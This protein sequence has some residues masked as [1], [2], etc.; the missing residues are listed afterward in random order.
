[1]EC[2]YPRG[3]HFPARSAEIQV[4]FAGGD[5]ASLPLDLA[6]DPRDSAEDGT[7]DFLRL[8]DEH[9]QQA[10]RQWFT[11]LAEAQYFQSAEARPT[12]INDCAALIR[13]AYREALVP[14]DGAW[15]ASA[16]LPLIPAFDSSAKYQ[17][18]YTALG[19]ALFRTKTGPFRA[20]DLRRRYVSPVRRRA[21]LMALQTRTS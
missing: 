18:P 17:Y 6:L 21:L 7:P 5:P 14:H 19:P 16:R 20:A 13:Y 9:D 4:S 15:A 1:M 10:F 2:A 12:E 8:E 11:Y 3:R